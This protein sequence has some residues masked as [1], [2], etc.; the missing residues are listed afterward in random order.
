[1]QPVHVSYFNFCVCNTRCSKKQKQINKNVCE[2]E[3]IQ[4]LDVLNLLVLQKLTD[5]KRQWSHSLE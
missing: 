5:F 3:S 1:M 2:E 4:N